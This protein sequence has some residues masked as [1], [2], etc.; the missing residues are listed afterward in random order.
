[1]L[2]TL[3]IAAVVMGFGLPQDKGLLRLERSQVTFLSE[4]PMETITATNTRST[5][6]LDPA[7]RTFA[8]QVPV[9]E[10]EGFNSPLQR[11]HFNENY[12]ESAVHPK[13]T[14]KGRIIEAVDLRTPGTH[15]IRAKGELS[16]KGITR[17]RIVPCTMVVSAKEVGITGAFDVALDEHEIRVPRVVQ[18]KIAPVV[19]VKLDLL[20]SSSP[21]K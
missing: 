10:F 19:Q 1:M 16:I 17:E 7:T 5:G 15:T 21:A 6:L 13:S 14:F 12:L 20:F 18:Q 8:V 11:E 3:S 9:A 4:A 2:R